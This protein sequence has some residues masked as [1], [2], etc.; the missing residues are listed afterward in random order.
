MIRLL[1]LALVSAAFAHNSFS[2][3]FIFINDKFKNLTSHTNCKKLARDNVKDSCSCCLVKKHLVENKDLIQATSH[4]AWH[5]SCSFDQ[6]ALSEKAPAKRAIERAKRRLKAMSVI[7]IDPS[8][9]DIKLMRSQ[10]LTKEAVGSILHTLNEQGHLALPLDLFRGEGERLLITPL[11]SSAKGLFSG[12]LFSIKYDAFYVDKSIKTPGK[13][14]RPLYILKETK[15][16]ITEI[17]NL[18]RIWTSPLGSD[19]FPTQKKIMGLGDKESSGIARLAF[20]DLHFKVKNGHCTRY[21]S[22]LQYAPGQSINSYLDDF[23]KVSTDH[24]G[25]GQY[26][27]QLSLMKKIFYRIGFAVSKLHQKYAEDNSGLDKTFTHGDLHSENIFY[28]EA[29]DTVTL[30]D[31]E[32]FALSLAHKKSGVNDLVEFYMLHTMRTVAHSF[33]S[34]LITNRKFGI[35]DGTWHELWRHLFFGYL[36]AHEHLPQKDMIDLYFDLKRNFFEG[37]SHAKIFSSVKNFLDQRMLKR[38]GA[39]MRRENIKRGELR[40]TFDE[41]GLDIMQHLERLTLAD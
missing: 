30:I 9:I 31:N 3:T 34:Q 39:S 33:S 27:I 19:K 4:C 22:L 26:F 23:G 21:F 37:L 41:L 8:D 10:M 32:T 7:D 24:L 35:D 5:L 25:S 36:T 2:E 1:S 18:Y 28:D 17:E 12:Q 6:K 38:L 11:G 29:S 16:G 14:Y 20:D 15:K 13:I 40:A